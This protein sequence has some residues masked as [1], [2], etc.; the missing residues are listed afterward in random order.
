M[1]AYRR[2]YDLRYL[3]ADLQESGS[4]PEPYSRLSSIDYLYLFT[5]QE[6]NV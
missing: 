1:A 6:I 5:Q 2:V 3:Q 4:A